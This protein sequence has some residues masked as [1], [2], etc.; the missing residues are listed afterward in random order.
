MRKLGTIMMMCAITSGAAAGASPTAKDSAA[1]HIEVGEPVIVSQGPAD[2]DRGGGSWGKWQFPMMRRLADS[3]LVV[4]F[5]VGADSVESYGKGVAWAISSDEGKTWQMQPSKPASEI[6][7]GVFLPNGERLRAVQQVSQSVGKLTLPKPICEFVCSFGSSWRLYP[8]ESFPPKMTQWVFER[9]VDGKSWKRETPTVTI[10][11]WVRSVVTE[12]SDTPGLTGQRE[13]L[14]ILP[15]L[16]GKMRI[17]PDQSL[18][19]VTYEWRMQG[20]RARY[21]PVFLRS[22]DGGH[23][24]RMQG[25]IRYQ[26]DIQADP[27]AE[28]RD[29]F[30]EPDYEFMPDGS[31]ICL[32]RTSDGCGLGPLYLT[33]STDNAK[34]WSKPVVFDSFGKIPQLLTLKNGVTLASYGQSG[35]PG[36]FVVRATKDPAGLAWTEPTKIT[37]SPGDGSAWDSCGHTEMVPLDDHSALLV[38]SDF[39]TPDANGVKRKTILVR[40]INVTSK[41]PRSVY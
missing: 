6:D 7:A 2:L 13:G 20:D 35:G 29:G 27:P 9:S 22:T 28:K 16:Q 37:Y 36:Y 32:M 23:A 14:V 18:W 3:R 30:T 31:L 33:R 8:P 26:P 41:S 25:E 10:P 34:T 19:A 5:S 1:I 21:V 12:R 11:D 38:Y 17:A 4:W 40:K 39:N 24:W 15:I